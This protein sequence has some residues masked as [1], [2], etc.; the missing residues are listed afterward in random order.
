VAQKLKVFCPLCLTVLDMGTSDKEYEIERFYDAI[1]ERFKANHKCLEEDKRPV[2]TVVNVLDDEYPYKI[3]LYAATPAQLS[4]IEEHGYHQNQWE[5]MDIRTRR[6]E[7]VKIY[8]KLYN[9]LTTSPQQYAEELQADID[10]ENAW[11]QHLQTK[12]RR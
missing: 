5:V 12:N 7:G 2:S 11:K 6:E 8:E 1:W 9:P 4:A 10:A 3:V